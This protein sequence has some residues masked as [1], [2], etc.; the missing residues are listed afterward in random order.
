MSAAMRLALFVLLAVGCVSAPKS[1]DPPPAAMPLR[2]VSYG[3]DWLQLRWPA[4]DGAFGYRVR[5]SPTTGEYPD[6]VDWNGHACAFSFSS[7][8]G[9]KDNL[10]WADVFELFDKRFTVFVT[11]TTVMSGHPER[12]DE[13]DVR[14]LHGRGFELASHSFDH[15]PLPF[16]DADVVVA[17]IV[18]SALYLEDV[19]D[20]PAYKCVTFAYP[21]SC[22][23]Q[24][25]MNLLMEYGYIA[26]RNGGK[27][28]TDPP[29]PQCCE[30]GPCCSSR[31]WAYTGHVPLYEIPNRSPEAAPNDSSEY[32]TRMRTQERIA[33]WKAGG[34][35]NESQWAHWL[36]HTLSQMDSL[37]LYWA[38]DEIVSDGD[39]WVAPVGVIA[40][41]VRQFHIDVRNPLDAD[42]LTCSAFVHEVPTDE[43]VHVIVEAYDH[44]YATMQTSDEL[45]LHLGRG[46][47]FPPGDKFDRERKERE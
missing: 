4:V 10:V 27:D 6:M 37:H 25:E 29:C 9:Y 22:H 16:C 8:D 28:A 36:R 1:A 5:H 33:R 43:W 40:R 39:V 42:S 2:I 17:N 44:D 12:L 3:E 15:L 18:G 23:T 46:W 41:Y 35:N 30:S 26:A 7:D 13:D 19:I 21:I 47:L 20:D 14:V 45:R 32:Y 34:P 11:A 38:L 24:R 31:T